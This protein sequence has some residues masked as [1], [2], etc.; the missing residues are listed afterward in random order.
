MGDAVLEL[1]RV[2]VKTVRLRICCCRVFACGVALVITAILGF[3]VFQ[4]D[5]MI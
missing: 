4:A 3:D 1:A 5:A 2:F